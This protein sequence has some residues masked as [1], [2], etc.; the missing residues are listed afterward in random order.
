MTDTTCSYPDK[1][2]YGSEHAAKDAIKAFRSPYGRMQAY[3]CG[4]HWHIGHGTRSHTTP[5]TRP[6]LEATVNQSI[7][8]PTCQAY[9]AERGDRIRA[10]IAKT[11]VGP[12]AEQK[13]RDFLAG[14]HD[15]HV[16]QSNQNRRALGRFSALLAAANDLDKETTR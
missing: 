5:K 7:P 10:E 16:E 15:R 2:R 6:A 13:W 8:C 1:K 3:P 14:V 12:A 9:D 11:L 4:G